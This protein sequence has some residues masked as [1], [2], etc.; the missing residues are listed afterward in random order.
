MV[1]LDMAIA[2]DTTAMDIQA[3]LTEK[4]PTNSAS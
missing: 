1:I 3:I 2:M 4:T